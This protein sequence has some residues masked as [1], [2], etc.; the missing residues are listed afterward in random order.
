MN[1][2]LGTKITAMVIAS[3][4]LL[5][6][7]IGFVVNLEITKGVKEFAVVKAKGDLRLA[8]KY[9]NEKYPGDWVVK[10]NKMYKGKILLNDNFQIVDEIGKDTGDTVTIFQGDSRVSTNV[11]KD[12]KRA[13]GTQ[14]S[15]EVASAVLK[16]AKNY[17]GE[18][19][20]AGHLYQ[21]AYAP[22][23]NK[24]G[25]VI[26]IFYVGASQKIINQI[27]SSFLIK[28]VTV[29]VIMIVISSIGVYWYTKRM[30]RRLASI[31]RALELAGN[32]DFTTVIHDHSKD[33]L[34]TLSSSY[35]QM[36]NNLKK[37]MN[38]VIATSEV[39][40]ASSE[41]LTASADLT[42]KATKNITSSI[43]EVASGAEQ[44]TASVKESAIAL[45][46][47]TIGVKSIADNTA[48]MTQFS[49][50][51]TEKAKEGGVYVQ[52]TV[53]QINEIRCTVSK[54]GEVIQSLDKRSN[55]IGDIIK[56]ISGISEQT[57]LLALNAAIEAA[58]A[59]EHGKGFAVVADEVRKLAEQSKDSS[60]RV[61]SLI[62]EIQQDMER[63]NQSI[64][65][66]SVA[67]NDG[68]GIVKQTEVS[69]KEIY[70]FL[71]QLANQINELAAIAEE[72]SASTQQVSVSIKGISDISHQTSIYSQNVSASANEQLLSMGEIAAAASSLSNMAAGL[73]HLI[74]QFKV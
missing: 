15:P 60:S 56:I 35:N 59:G 27:L 32:G 52:K 17:Y 19:D 18:A 9:I 11:L 20:V 21:T 8:T 5:S 44:S 48:V 2:K 50:Q 38:E 67:V 45:E 73:Q 51:A 74:S 36:S 31:G 49:T 25:Q 65:Q 63:S 23:K 46:E 7:M 4:L 71:L 68:L 3:I 66:V 70:H 12:G 62:I 34:G 13:T 54:S 26:G 28:F 41:E 30:R 55:E 24:N 69:F 22:I 37:M 14:A 42:S 16:Q 39:V 43:Q 58:R 29:L 10:D 47:V 72:I 40:A 64:E 61:A 33:E 57:N 53:D 1:L 6:V